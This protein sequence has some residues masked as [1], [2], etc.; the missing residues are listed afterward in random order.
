[1]LYSTLLRLL[2]A[3]PD[4]QLP[5]VAAQIRTRIRQLEGEHRRL[6]AEL[7]KRFPAYVDLVSP[8]PA[9]SQEERARRS[10]KARP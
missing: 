3:P 8:R 2:S 4:Q 9:T 10:A 7:E 5:Q 1:V 6:F